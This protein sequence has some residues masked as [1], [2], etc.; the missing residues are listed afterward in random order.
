MEYEPEFAKCFMQRT[1]A[2]ASGYQGPYDATLLINCLVGLL[3]VPKEILIEKVP[4][5]P[6]ESLIDWGVGPH[7]IKNSGKCEYGHKHT[8]NL[9]Q[10]VR[11]LRNA[12]AHFKIDPFPKQGNV[13]GFHF[14]DRNGF[15]ASLSLPEIKQFVTKLSQHLESVA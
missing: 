12:V 7:S 14:Q 5:T 3:V 6:L 15:H 9:R 11:R 8:L 10:L 4:D 13:K 1:L 2:I